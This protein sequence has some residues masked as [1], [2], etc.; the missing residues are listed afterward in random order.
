MDN[1]RETVPTS[2]TGSRESTIAKVR[3]HPPHT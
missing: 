2:R 1:R 3:L